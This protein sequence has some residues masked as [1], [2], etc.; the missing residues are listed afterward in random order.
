MSGLKVF[1][2]A[3]C[4]DNKSENTVWAFIVDP[5]GPQKSLV[6]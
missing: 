2:K 3:D 4:I 6:L 1:S 5:T